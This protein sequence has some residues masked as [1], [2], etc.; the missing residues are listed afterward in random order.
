MRWLHRLLTRF[1]QQQPVEIHLAEGFIGG[2]V[3]ARVMAKRACAEPRSSAFTCCS[4]PVAETINSHFDS[5]P[6]CQVGRSLRITTGLTT[7]SAKV[8]AT[9]PTSDWLESVFVAV[10]RRRAVVPVTLRS[11]ASANIRG[12]PAG[13]RGAVSLIAHPSL[14]AM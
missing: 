9:N 8:V 10:T 4:T 6:S 3:T 14:F 11:R 5:P 13:L 12:A 2:T 1:P 7:T